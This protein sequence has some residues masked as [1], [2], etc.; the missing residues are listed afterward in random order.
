MSTSGDNNMNQPA[1]DFENYVPNVAYTLGDYQPVR[2]TYIAHDPFFFM[3]VDDI[4]LEEELLREFDNSFGSHAEYRDDEDDSFLNSLVNFD[5]NL[6]FL[7]GEELQG[8]SI[9]H[10]KDTLLKSR[11]AAS[12]LE[13]A[14]VNNIEFV[15]C[16]QIV[17]VEYNR[18]ENVILFQPLL[19][20]VELIKGSICALRQ[21]WQ[22]YQGALL[23]PV[24]LYPDHAV[25]VNRAQ[26]ADVVSTLL[27]CAW[28]LELAGE[29]VLWD[30]LETGSMRDLTHAFGREAAL[31]FRSLNNGRAAFAAFES[32]FLSDRSRT[33]D[34]ALIQKMLTDYNGHQFE[35]E[36]MSQLVVIDLIKALGEMPYGKNYLAW[37]IPNLL[38]DP[39]FTEVR[40]RSAANFLWF[41][42]FEKTFTEVEQGLQ[43]EGKLSTATSSRQD[44]RSLNAQSTGVN[45]YDSDAAQTGILIPFPGEHRS[46]NATSGDAA[47]AGKSGEVIPFDI[48]VRPFNGNYF[49]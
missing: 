42:K 1:P 16:P 41:I 13:F 27:R 28:E 39:I 14:D 49:S 17:D 35:D 38:T 2:S 31:D 3:D 5:E 29:Y 33:A 26:K 48:T 4:T 32:W 36:D 20:E 40:E 18:E 25:F 44:G 21:A 46:K 6:E 37:H 10:I 15:S 47:R 12:L 9:D 34:N 43:K 45:N 8:Q 30:D 23:Q 19:S 11:F 22:N 24:A 7:S